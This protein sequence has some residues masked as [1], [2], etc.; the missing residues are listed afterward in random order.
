MRAHDELHKYL[1]IS[2]RSPCLSRVSRHNFYEALDI[3]ANFSRLLK[4][5]ALLSARHFRIIYWAIERP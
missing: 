1:A 4:L 5:S 2:E 3:C